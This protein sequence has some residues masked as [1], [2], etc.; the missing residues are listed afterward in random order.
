MGLT[1]EQVLNNFGLGNKKLA[2]DV[3]SLKNAENFTYKIINL[4]LVY[5][6]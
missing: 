6:R 3:E 5:G 1:L 4:T 2:I